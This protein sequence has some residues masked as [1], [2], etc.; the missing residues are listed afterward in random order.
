MKLFFR[1]LIL[2]S[3]LVAVGCSKPDTTEVFTYGNI[4]FGDS[5]QKLV[6]QGYECS[7]KENLKRICEKKL[8][9]SSKDSIEIRDNVVAEISFLGDYQD[10]KE[11]VA[12]QYR[13]KYWLMGMY[14]TPQEM[15]VGARGTV[16]SVDTE[17]YNGRFKNVKPNGTVYVHYSVSCYKRKDGLYSAFIRFKEKQQ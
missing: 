2:C 10:K 12:K 11:C 7:V 13:F 15:R 8:S 6:E 3:L 1:S 5:E 14:N 4:K 16:Y 17:S 9:E